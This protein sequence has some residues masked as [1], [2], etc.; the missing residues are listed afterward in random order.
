MGSKRIRL[1]FT[2]SEFMHNSQVRNLCDLVSGLDRS[3]FEI[4]I[5]ALELGN[6]GQPLI[7]ELDVPVSQLRLLLPPRNSLKELRQFLA[8]PGL[9]RRKRY[10]IVHSLMWQSQFIEPLVVKS[11]TSARYVYTK[12]NLHWDNHRISWNWKSRLSDKIISISSATDDVLF[13]HGFRNKTERA[14]LGIDTNVF[15]YSEQK[16][17]AMRNRH[18]LPRDAFVYGCAAHFVE[19]KDH[20]TL[21]SAF[22]SLASRYRNVRLLLCGAHHGDDYYR[23]VVAQIADSPYKSRITLLGALDDMH[24]FY[25]ALDCFVFPSYWDAFGLVVA[26]AMS[27]RLPC[28]ACRTQGPLD[29]IEEGETGFFCEPRNARDMAT[30]ME[31]YLIDSG[32]GKRHGSAGQIRATRLF[33]REAMVARTTHVYLSLVAKS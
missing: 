16:R 18:G 23:R 4:E 28:V 17:C 20:L 9:L 13:R 8:A 10:D 26:E 1:L 15:A 19:I 31:K 7:E 22:E 12:S 27:C 33:S 3:V 6:E 25:S 24:G 5:S 14:P 2:A 21:V 30:Q 32:L 29:M 11:F